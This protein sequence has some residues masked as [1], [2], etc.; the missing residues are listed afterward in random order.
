MNKKTS[1]DCLSTVYLCMQAMRS[2]NEGI[3]L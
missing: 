3:E 2:K 1:C